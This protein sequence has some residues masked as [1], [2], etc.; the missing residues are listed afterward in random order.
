M[1]Q[2]KTGHALL[3]TEDLPVLIVELHQRINHTAHLPEII[4]TQ[5]TTPIIEIQGQT[6]QAGLIAHLPGTTRAIP[7]HLKTDQ[8]APGEVTRHPVI[9]VQTNLT[10]SQAPE[11]PGQAIQVLQTGHHH[12]EEDK[13]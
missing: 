5:I 7:A 2:T 13:F 9:Q 1:N 3:P 12:Q 4:Q 6:L 8:T 10:A 11:V